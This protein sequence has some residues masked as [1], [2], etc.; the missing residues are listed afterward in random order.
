MF[1]FIV[2]T[3]TWLALDRDEVF[4]IPG[5]YSLNLYRDQYGG[6][7][8]LYVKNCFKAKILSEFTVLDYSYEVLTVELDLCFCKCVLV[9]VYH[10]PSSFQR[11]HDFINFFTLKLRTILNLK[12]PVIVAGDFNL[13]L[14]NPNNFSYTD[15]FINNMF[16][17]NMLPAVTRPTRITRVNKIV[18][19]YLLDQIWMSTGTDQTRSCVVPVNITDHFP[20]CLVLE[21][22]NLGSNGSK[23]IEIKIFFDRNKDT[24]KECLRGRSGFLEI[25]CVGQCEVLVCL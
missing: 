16:E 10:P 7:L 19:Y 18:R 25:V 8:R 5:F 9:M 2:L 11:N 20:V 24:F 1:T 15:T 21:N 17:L 3:E 13:N 22:M 12:M 4:N 23:M 14:F 6:G